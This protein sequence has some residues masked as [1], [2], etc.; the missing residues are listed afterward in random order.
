MYIQARVLEWLKDFCNGKTLSIEEE[1]E[2]YFRKR[3]E[4]GLK[5]GQGRAVGN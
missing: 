1:Y 3:E 4:T 2:S 5:V